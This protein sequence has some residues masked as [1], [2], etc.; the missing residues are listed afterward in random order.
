MRRRWFNTP[1]LC[2]GS[3]NDEIWIAALN[4]LGYEGKYA[5]DYY[6]MGCVEIMIPGKQPNWGV[7]D[8]IAFPMVFETVFNRFRRGDLALDSFSAFS[9][10]YENALREAL[11]ADYEEARTKQADIPGKC[12]DPFAS[13]MIDGCLEK[14]QDMFQGGSELGTHWSFY[15]YGLGTAA[16]AMAAVKKLVYDEKRL[17]IQ[18]MSEILERNFEG[19]EMY[20]LLMDAKAPKYGNDDDEA[21]TLARDILSCFSSGVMELNKPEERDKYVSTLF[22]YFFHIYH[23]EITGATPNGR[24]RGETFSDSMGPSQGKDVKGPAKMLNSVLKLDHKEV[25]G[26]YALN[27]KLNR[28]LVHSE[29][30]K[31]ALK[32]LLKGYLRDGGPQ[33]QINF[34]DAESLRRAM[35]DPQGYRNLIVRIGGYCEYFVNLDRVLQE[36]IITRTI[37]GI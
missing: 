16:D 13:L 4:Q 26:G 34:V 20:R 3:N 9:G 18:A 14:G 35:E 17:S 2:F 28:E 21:D 22:G 25:T 12:Y 7:T 15:A 31:R 30:G 37:H 27:L 32:G 33:I 36:E 19:D 5:N 6:N 1:E 29:A 23:G 11:L 8:P 10:A 24:R